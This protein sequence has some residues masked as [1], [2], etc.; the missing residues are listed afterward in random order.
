MDEVRRSR[1]DQVVLEERI[2]PAP[3]SE[4]VSQVL[5][6]AVLDG[7]LAVFP[8]ADA[9]PVVQARAALL[10]AHFGDFPEF[11]S[12]AVRDAVA[13]LAGGRRSLSELKPLSLTAALLESLSP[14]QR[15]RLRREAPEKIELRPGRAV[16]VHYE[17]GKPPW[18]ASR[19]QDFIGMTETPRICAGR[20]PLVAH[21][22]A[23]NGRPVQVTQDLPGFWQRHYPALRRQLQRRY[24]RHPWPDLS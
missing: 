7:R 17:A 21:L 5:A 23:P 10:A 3:V 14:R 18:V 2:R 1:Y 24:P 9:I 16:K 12:E 15:E 8:D 20:V 13:G 4:D 11:G 6:A 19:L 22:L